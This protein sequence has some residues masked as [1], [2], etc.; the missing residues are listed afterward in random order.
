M[1]ESYKA[2]VLLR[3]LRRFGKYLFI[4]FILT[5]ILAL[6]EKRTEHMSFLARKNRF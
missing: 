2:C 3:I 1:D 4:F 6:Y 5:Y